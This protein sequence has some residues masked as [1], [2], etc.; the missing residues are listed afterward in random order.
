[1]DVHLDLFGGLAGD[2]FIAALL[3]ACPQFEEAV[4]TAIQSLSCLAPVSCSLLAHRDSILT[5]RRF[6][7]TAAL[8][9]ARLPRSAAAHGHTRW[10]SLRHDLEHS[11]LEPSVRRHAVG[12]FELLAQAEGVVHGVCADE[13][14]FHEVGAW[15]SVADIVGAAVLIDALGAGHW[16]YSA[17]PLGSGQVQTAHGWLPVPA[18]ATTRLLLGM[19]TIDDGI[20][21]E[22]V[23]PTGA[24]ILRYLC[25]PPGAVRQSAPAPV[26]TLLSSGT[27]FGF[28]TLA[29]RSNH[30]RVLCFA[31]SSVSQGGHRDFCSVEFEVDDQ[32]AEDLAVGLDRLRSHVGVLDVTQSC[33]IGKKGR[34]MAHV[35][36]LAQPAQ[37]DAVVDACFRETTTIGLRVQTVRGIGLKRSF[38]EV[39]IDGQPVRVK[40]VERP[41]GS[42]AKAESDDLARRGQSSQRAAVRARAEMAALAFP[43][44]SPLDA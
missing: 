23:T 7:V 44:G 42:T 5:G 28:R 41:G 2:M 11:G 12:I 10:H 31:N 4:L 18:P 13:V 14:E 20:G 26:R 43:E 35:R 3:D 21:G 15:D 22:R 1:V 8:P 17:V 27:G 38:R 16:T 34:S 39:L 9:P 33:V 30:L 25:P 37:V 24:A 40:V 36:V 6:S 19:R 29:G 32:S